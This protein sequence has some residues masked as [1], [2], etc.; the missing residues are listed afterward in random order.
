[1]AEKGVGREKVD[2]AMLRVV[3]VFGINEAQGAED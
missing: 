3:A 1:M 2:E